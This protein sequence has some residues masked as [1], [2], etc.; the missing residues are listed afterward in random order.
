MKPLLSQIFR[1]R[2]LIDFQK[3]HS[4]WVSYNFPEQLPHQPLLGLAEEVGELAHA[5]L[6]REQGIRGMDKTVAVDAKIKDSIGDIM[7]YL[8][9]YCNANGYSL[10]LCFIDAWNEI[11]DRDWV[12]YPETGKPVLVENME[13]F[14]VHF[15]GHLSDPQFTEHILKL[16]KDKPTCDAEEM[17]RAENPKGTA[18]GHTSA[19]AAVCAAEGPVETQRDVEHLNC[20]LRNGHSSHYWIRPGYHSLNRQFFCR[21]INF[22][23]HKASLTPEV[24]EAQIAALKHEIEILKARRNEAED[25]LIQ[26]DIVLNPDDAC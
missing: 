24:Y 19:E 11:K 17:F 22:D 18:R 2:E 1:F 5:H 8:T 26:I 25:K 12:N 13:D 15:S 7:I 14:R 21:G 23:N 20:P 6:K 9:S 4:K 16:G 10:A 3:A